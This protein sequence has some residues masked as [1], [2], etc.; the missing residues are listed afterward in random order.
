M[1]YT[2]TA[3]DPQ[4]EPDIDDPDP[5]DVL[6]DRVDDR[7][8]AMRDIEIA[9]VVMCDE[10]TAPVDAA[11]RRIVG[12][13]LRQALR[14]PAGSHV[15]VPVDSDDMRAVRAFIRSEIEEEVR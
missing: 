8:H 5:A 13:L 10:V 7:L 6:A 1:L 15:A 2:L 3:P 4:C 9:D 11:L 14:L 12:Q